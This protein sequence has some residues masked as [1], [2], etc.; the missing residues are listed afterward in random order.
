[1]VEKKSAYYKMYI[2]CGDKYTFWD[3]TWLL[4]FR[5]KMYADMIIKGYLHVS[6]VGKSLFEESGVY[7][8]LRISHEFS[9][10]PKKKEREELAENHWK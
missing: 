3:A 7:M 5:K 8:L 6:R 2:F 10:E 4:A 1:M 9:T